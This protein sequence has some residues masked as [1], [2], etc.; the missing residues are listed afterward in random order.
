M[1]KHLFFMTILLGLMVIGCGKKDESSNSDG[2]SAATPLNPACLNGSAY[3][4]P[5]TYSQYPG[6]YPNYSGITP[7]YGGYNWCGC[8]SGAYPVYHGQIGNGCISAPYAAPYVNSGYYF[9]VGAQFNLFPYAGHPG[10]AWMGPSYAPNNH[11]WVNIQQYSSV[12]P[13]YGNTCQQNAL[14]ACYVD[15]PGSCGNTGFTC[16][17]TSGGSRLGV[18]AR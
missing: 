14:L 8:R 11:Q 1:K 9:Y 17:P 12:G 7:S 4:D 3:C 18:C 10:R 13:N 5:S 6:F 2:S 15:V 16:R